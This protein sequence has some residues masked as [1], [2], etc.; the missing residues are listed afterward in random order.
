MDPHTG[1]VRAL[2]G[3]RDFKESKFNRATQALRQPGSTFK[4]FVFTAAI[5]SGMPISHVMVDSPFSMP[6]VD[7]TLWEPKNYDP[8]LPRP[9]EPA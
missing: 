3:G 1:E 6:Q 5:A 4:P 7:G 2:I 8:G 9:G